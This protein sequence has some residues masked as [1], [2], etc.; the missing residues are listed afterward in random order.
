MAVQHAKALGVPHWYAC[1]K[2]RSLR[3]TRAGAGET[4]ATLNSIAVAEAR[5]KATTWGK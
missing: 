4:A 1:S 3:G 2:A 5:K